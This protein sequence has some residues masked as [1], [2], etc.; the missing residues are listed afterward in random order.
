M[1]VMRVGLSI[2]DFSRVTHLSVKTL[3]RYHESGLLDPAEVDS[4]TGYRYYSTA[5]IPTAQVILHFREL[6]MPV[7]RSVRCWRRRTRKPGTS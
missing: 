6:G 5:Q 2:G 1:K 7:R 4:A 3:R